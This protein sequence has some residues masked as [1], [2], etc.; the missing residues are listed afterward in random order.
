M[1]TAIYD[2]IRKRFIQVIKG[3]NLESEE[4]VIQAA[5][6]SSKEAIGNPKDNDYPL[7]TGREH[8]MQAEFRNYFGQA[9]PLFPWLQ[10]I[11]LTRV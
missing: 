5:P 3:N 10:I 2:I 8:L 4:V 9:F 7:I 6:L 11:T 1:K